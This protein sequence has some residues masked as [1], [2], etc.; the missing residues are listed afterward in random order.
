M[1]VVFISNTVLLLGLFL[2]ACEGFKLTGSM[3]ESLEPGQVP[4]EC[5]TYNEEEA[6]KASSPI[7]NKSGECLECQT[8]KGLEIR[9]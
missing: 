4:S 1:R 8:S 3:C 9:Q 2:S 5:K 7:K 6:E